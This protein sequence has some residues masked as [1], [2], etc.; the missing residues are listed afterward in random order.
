MK[1]ISMVGFIEW[2]KFENPENFVKEDFSDGRLGKYNVV[3]QYAN[4]LK[5]PLT[6]G[7]FVPCDEDG[8]VLEI[9]TGWGNTNVDREMTEE[10]YFYQKAKERVLF[11]HDFTGEEII[12]TI[13]D[14]L[15]CEFNELCIEDFI[16]MWC[17]SPVDMSLTALTQIGL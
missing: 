7:M 12:D 8:N 15:L 4:F 14:G 16:I 3:Y 1:L 5:Q 10:D 11:T 17:E 6:L 2:I 9:P 13:K